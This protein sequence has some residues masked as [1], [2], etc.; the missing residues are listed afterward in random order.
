MEATARNLTVTT[1]LDVEADAAINV[2]E[3]VT[4]KEI[5]VGGAADINAA[6]ATVE[7]LEVSGN[8]DVT[9][10]GDLNI[11]D[12]TVGGDADITT[13]GNAEMGKVA[14][15]GTT[16]VDVEGKLTVGEATLTGAAVLDAKGELN[17]TRLEAT[18]DLTVKSEANATVGAAKVTGKLTANITG[19]AT[20]DT[21]AAGSVEATAKNLTV[22][23][24]LDVTADATINATE[25]VTAKE[26]TV[27]GAADIDAT[28]AT[29]EVLNVTGNAEVTTT[30]DLAITDAT[31]GGN[32]DITAG[33]NVTARDLQAGT[34]LAVS[35]QAVTFQTMAA[36]EITLNAAGAVTDTAEAGV[37]NIQTQ[38]LTV[39]ADSFGTENNAITT[40][41]T[42]GAELALEARK[43][44]YL[45]DHSEEVTVSSFAAE[46]AEADLTFHGDVT[47]TVDMAA[48][49]VKLKAEGVAILQ[50]ITSGTDATLEIGDFADI[51]DVQA[52]GNTRIKVD[53]DLAGGK[54]DTMNLTVTTLGAAELT[55]V[56]AVGHIRLDTVGRLNVEDVDANS[57]MLT[58]G[59]ALTAGKLSSYGPVVISAVNVQLNTVEGYEVDITVDKAL[60]F[61]KLAATANVALNSNSLIESKAGSEITAL[62]GDITIAAREGYV[63]EKT[64]QLKAEGKV[65]ISASGAKIVVNAAVDAKELV[66]R[67]AKEVTAVVDPDTGKLNVTTVADGAQ[68]QLELTNAKDNAVNV[69]MQG[70]NDTLVLVSGADKNHFTVKADSITLENKGAVKVTGLEN[71]V[72]DSTGAAATVDI[73]EMPCA[74]TVN[75]GSGDDV[76]NVGM[77]LTEK[78][79]DITAVEVEE[80]WLT[81]GS[82]HK[83]TVNTGSGKDRINGHSIVEALTVSGGS[84]SDT[85][86]ITEYGYAEGIEKYP[87]GPFGAHKDTESVIVEKIVDHYTIVAGDNLYDLADRFNVTVDQLY[88]WNADKIADPKLIYPG[89]VLY[90]GRYRTEQVTVTERI[91]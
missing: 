45:E 65:D 42:G 66:L 49:S 47:C 7:T 1:K 26:I 31:V 8:A 32:A 63:S 21:A 14:V 12:A 57:M 53:G 55:Q 10:T 52:A 79:A 76:V 28:T 75:T 40:K 85:L 50:N 72:I 60:Q 30:G 5:T 56:T 61:S 87:I 3:A 46:N 48:N 25:A 83:L 41:L 73:F 68:V 22:G 69:D 29:D 70:K 88:A 2:T 71:A 67:D 38:K 59:S 13:G 54:V 86:Y 90:I 62:Y 33:G 82:N 80:G 17:A 9:T 84:D 89:Q 43:A 18:A 15:T 91:G 81:V 39:K 34:A 4:A 16:T 24:K 64:A 74:M 37:T 11:T 51:G 58:A 19:D 27:G 44:L 36:K 23:T 6:T 78:P 35:G 20:I 77:L